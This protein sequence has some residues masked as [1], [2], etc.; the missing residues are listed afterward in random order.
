L[1]WQKLNWR[2]A[3]DRCLRM[4]GRTARTL[5]ISEHS[6]Q[7]LLAAIFEFLTMSRPC[8]IPGPSPGTWQVT[9]PI[10][11][12][13]R[14]RWWRSWRKTAN[15]WC[16]FRLGSGLNLKRT[17]QNEQN[18]IDVPQQCH[19]HVKFWCQFLRVM[20]ARSW[21]GFIQNDT[22]IA[23]PITGLGRQGSME[24]LWQ[25]RRSRNY[26]NWYQIDVRK[27]RQE[28]CAP[29]TSWVC[30][31]YVQQTSTSNFLC[32]FPPVRPQHSDQVGHTPSWRGTVLPVGQ[33]DEDAS[34]S[35][36]NIRVLN[37]TAQ[38]LWDSKSTQY[39]TSRIGEGTLFGKINEWCLEMIWRCFEECSCLYL[40]LSFVPDGFEATV[41]YQKPTIIDLIESPW[42]FFF[43]CFS[44]GL[45]S[46][47]AG[48]SRES[49]W[50]GQPYDC[51]HTQAWGLLEVSFDRERLDRDGWEHFHR[52]AGEKLDRGRFD[53]KAGW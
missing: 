26:T 28:E 33:S 37:L 1:E 25:T 47:R 13:T 48:I 22:A 32:F 51:K 10:F 16:V 5:D 29:T 17:E 49:L 12:A 41:D 38:P 18:C 19:T 11:Y 53:R 24:M 44:Y 52:E 40:A 4:S 35:V 43:P 21:F 7:P 23:S 36:K 39:G 9:L 6:N 8:L 46:K 34:Q 15:I 3:L 2:K 50:G 42:D 14:T 31:Q 27:F 20:G 30:S 45:N